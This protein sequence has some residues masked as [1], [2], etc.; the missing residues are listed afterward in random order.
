[1]LSRSGQDFKGNTHG[2]EKGCGANKPLVAEDI[3]QAS[4]NVPIYMGVKRG[5]RGQE[6]LCQDLSPINPGTTEPA[7]D[8]KR[9]PHPR[10]SVGAVISSLLNITPH[11]VPERTSPWPSSHRCPSPH[12]P[13][14]EGRIAPVG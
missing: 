6:G 5:Q 11:K 4:G 8:V 13:V 9:S 1:M 12:I 2:L 14:R 7:L 3:A 10:N